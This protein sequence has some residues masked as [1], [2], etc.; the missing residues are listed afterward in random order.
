MYIPD[1]SE[2][3][4]DM[5]GSPYR[6]GI[7]GAAGTGKTWAALTFPN[8]VVLNLDN[9]LGAHLHRTDILNIKFH[10][11]DFIK[12]LAEKFGMS[13]KVGTTGVNNQVVNRFNVF[14]AWIN[15]E[16]QKF[17]SD[18][19]V[20]VDSATMLSN[21]YDA[22]A[23]VT[24]EMSKKTGEINTQEL[25][26][27]K[28]KLFRQLFEAFKSTQAT[29]IVIFHESREINI[30]GIP[31]GKYNALMTGST[32]EYLGQHFTDWYR[33]TAE[34]EIDPVTKKPTGNVNYWWQ[35]KPNDACNCFSSVPRIIHDP[36][37]IRVPATYQSLI[38]K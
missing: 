31:T 6:I 29:L 4:S 26:G 24:P 7:Q 19:T 8:P 23:E 17:T 37:I 38:T 16:L 1:Y 22:F 3:L 5:K 33:Q 34:N 35:V 21:A 9:K 2:K 28:L 15:A 10:D 30:D 11:N 36:K 14:F 20:I 18:Q 12:K 13:Y 27:R 25:W 32:R